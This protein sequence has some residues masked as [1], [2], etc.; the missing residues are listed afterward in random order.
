MLA[1]VLFV[2]EFTAFKHCSLIFCYCEAAER[3]I[4]VITLACGWDDVMQICGA[5]A[6]FRYYDVCGNDWAV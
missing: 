6:R 3:D 4:C 1:S 5:M 2:S